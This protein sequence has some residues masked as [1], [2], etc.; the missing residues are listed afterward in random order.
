M[1]ENKKHGL[2]VITA[3]QFN[4]APGRFEL[5]PGDFPDAPPCPFGN[6]YKWIGY[7]TQDKRYVRVTKSVFKK[8]IG[9]MD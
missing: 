8:L 7:D 9:K 4:A 6:Q 1:K 2:P 3:A 5:R